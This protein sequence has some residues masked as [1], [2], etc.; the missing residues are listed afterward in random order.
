MKNVAAHLSEL[1][2]II[3]D[4]F[5]HHF[6]DGEVLENVV[7]HAAA[8]FGRAIAMP[9]TNPPI[10]TT[11][12]AIAYK[13]RISEWLPKG[14]DL[15]VLMTIYMTDNTRPEELRKAKASGIVY[16]CKLYPAG[17]T[18]NSEFGVTKL[19]KI[20]ACLEVM[21]EIDLPLLVHGEVTDEDIDIFDRERI[22][23]ERILRPMVERFPT[24]KIVMEHI[25]T[26]EAVDF[27][28]SCGPNVAATITA[29]HMLYNRNELFKGGICPHFYC[30]PVLKREQH[31]QA[32]IDAAT[33]G[34]PKFFLGTDSAPHSVEKKQ[35]ACGCAGIFTSH[36]GIEL[37]AEVFDAAGKIDL[38]EA[39][40]SRYGSSFY[41]L[42]P[43]SRKIVL[44][45]ETWQVPLLYKFGSNVVR[46]LR[47]G[48]EIAWRIV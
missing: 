34:S 8:R 10:C 31:R 7:A 26:K 13:G 30:L 2:I 19:D 17:A 22:F 28:S 48:E 37:Y 44:K 1:E 32:L 11:E 42:S 15:K 6:R 16:A 40:A 24:L 12:D 21:A 18:T 23:I 25:T 35:S 9:N 47:A 3:P 14:S 29:H 45:R 36:A 20:E 41:G 27:V 46:P 4:D 33:S 39:F 5:H 43:N 38:L